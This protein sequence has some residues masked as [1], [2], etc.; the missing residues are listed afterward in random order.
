M[1]KTN[2]LKHP[3]TYAFK[4]STIEKIIEK[5]AKDFGDSNVEIVSLIKPQFEVGKVLAKKYKGVIKDKKLHAE[6]I[7]RIVQRFNESGFKN[8]GI[9]ISPILGGD[10][11]TEFLGYFKNKN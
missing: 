8:F 2:T 1:L 6:V 10:G 5:L 4:A 11:N 7:E 9:T 3:S